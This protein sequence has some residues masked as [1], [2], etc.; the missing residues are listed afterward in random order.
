MAAGNRPGAAGALGE[1]AD[2]AGQLGAGPIRDEA[3]DLIKRARLGREPATVGTNGDV[4]S[5]PV[6]GRSNSQIAEELFIGPKTASVHVS[7]LLG[8]LG[9]ATRVEAA[10]AAY[11]LGFTAGR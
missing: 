3:R 4:T 9:V 1:P 7:N 6:A 2:L 10:A 8:K 5:D 11:R